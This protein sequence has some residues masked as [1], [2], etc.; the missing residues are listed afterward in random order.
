VITQEKIVCRE[1]KIVEWWESR[2]K[3]SP[4]KGAVKKG[5]VRR[6]KEWL[7]KECYGSDAEVTR[8]TI[9]QHR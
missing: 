4:S 3:E 5:W 6:G 7:C 9:S 2:N 8:E 1:C